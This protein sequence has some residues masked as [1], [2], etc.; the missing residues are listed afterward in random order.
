VAVTS[1]VGWATYL[2]RLGRR[3]RSN[4][5]GAIE[6]HD[7]RTRP[8]SRMP[9][10][11]FQLVVPDT[12]SVLD[13]HEICD[14]IEDAMLKETGDA[15]ITIHGSPRIGRNDTEPLVLSSTV[16]IQWPPS[17]VFTGARRA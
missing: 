5:G 15:T 4:A 10:I 6:A 17:A 8:A 14:R 11:E 7:L 16:S 2:A 9:F 3:N 1:N 12:M 13:S